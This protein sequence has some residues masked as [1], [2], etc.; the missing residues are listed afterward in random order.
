MI[1]V[2]IAQKILLLYITTNLMLHK[3][4][5]L[6]H[7]NHYYKH[8]STKIEPDSL[9]KHIFLFLDQTSPNL[10]KE[11]VSNRYYFTI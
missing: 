1:W 2:T 7:I 9:F 8:L 4:F 6:F 10:L 5:N 11:G 3:L